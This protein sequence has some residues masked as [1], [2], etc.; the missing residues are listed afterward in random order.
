MNIIE[1]QRLIIDQLYQLMVESAENGFNT[2]SCRFE[3][4]AD[5][6]GSRAVDTAFEYEFNGSQKSK[7]LNY[8]QIKEERPI[9]LVPKLH[10][11]MK[12]HTGGAWDAFTLSIE[13]DGRVTTKFEYPE[14]KPTA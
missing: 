10:Q 11:L 3:Y 8:R 1:K 5:E 7:H 12:E 9:R 14:P 13:Q 6:D 2:A 4:Y